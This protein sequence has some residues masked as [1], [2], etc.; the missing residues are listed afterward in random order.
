M[1]L[2]GVQTGYSAAFNET[3][4]CPFVF[5]VFF[6]SLSLFGNI[7]LTTFW[8][9]FHPRESSDPGTLYTNR[10]AIYLYSLN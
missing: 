7:G 5:F 3:L 2:P 1:V 6:F 9:L 8:E 4:V 10:G